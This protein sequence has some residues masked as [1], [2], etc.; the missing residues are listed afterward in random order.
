MMIRTIGTATRDRCQSSA[1][2]RP[3]ILRLAAAFL[4]LSIVL[5]AIY[6]LGAPVPDAVRHV[7]GGHRPVLGSRPTTQTSVRPVR[8]TVDAIPPPGRA[9]SGYCPPSPCD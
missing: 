5:G 1:P 2:L 7:S 4:V 6:L 3:R 8:L 9:A